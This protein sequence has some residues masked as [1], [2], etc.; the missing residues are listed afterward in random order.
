MAFINWNSKFSVQIKEIDDQHKVL[1]NLLNELYDSMES[2][3]SEKVIGRIIGE[4]VEYTA[5]HFRTEETYFDNF[6]YKET[7]DHKQ[8]HRSLIK[9]L[10]VIKSDFESGKISVSNDLL[11]FLKQWLF[12]HILVT[13]KEYIDCFKANGI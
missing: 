1:V 12:E 2:K 11:E 9:K 13:D 8:K 5:F 7:V 6:N 3:D 10:F 4:L